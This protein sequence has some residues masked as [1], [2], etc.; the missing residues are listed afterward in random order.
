ML[1]AISASMAIYGFLIFL[2]KI[3]SVSATKTP[4]KHEFILHEQVHAKDKTTTKK[5]CKLII[6]PHVFSQRRKAKKIGETATF[7]CNECKKLNKYV[8]AK[9]KKIG[10]NEN[11]F[12]L[13]KYPSLDEHITHSTAHLKTKFFESMYEKIKNNPSADMPKLYEKIV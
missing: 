10:E 7:V 9:A 1:G 4:P 12:E 13:L 5:S 3:V 2:T 6:E 8:T 11:D